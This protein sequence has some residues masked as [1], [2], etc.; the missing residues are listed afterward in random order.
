MIESNSAEIGSGALPDA[1]PFVRSAAA[2][3]DS[4]RAVALALTVAA[5]LLLRVVALGSAGFSEDEI[6]KLHAVNAYRHGDFSANGE[7]PMLMKVAMW[8]SLDGARWWNARVNSG[9]P[10]AISD[11]AAL[12]LPNA[13]AGAA[14]AAVLFL[15]TE[16]LFDTPTGA[17]AA[18]FW[19]CDVGA[20]GINRIG[21]EDTFLLF[22]L[23]LGAYL[24]ERGKQVRTDLAARERWYSRSA[25]AFGL[26]LAS[27][28]MPHYFGLHALFNVAGDQHPEDRTPDKRWPFFVVMAMAFVAGNAALLLPSTWRYVLGYVHGDTLRHSG[29]LFAQHLYVNNLDAS[30]WGLP[31]W[32]YAAFLA[33]KESLVTLGAAAVGA[34]WMWRHPGHRGGAFVRVFLV[35]TLLPY[36]FAASK[37]LRY[38]LPTLAAIDI[39]AAIGAARLVRRT[40]DA[41]PFATA[42]LVCA[43]AVPAIAAAPHY[44][45]A[46]N[47]V[48]ERLSPSLMFP[49]DELYDAGVR[50]AVGTVA[51]VASPGAVICSDAT[52]VVAEYLARDGRPDVTSRSIAH[53]GIPMRGGEVWVIAQDGHVY[54]ENAATLDAIQRRLA[55]WTEIRVG[56]V[57]AVRVYR[58]R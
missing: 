49:D 7:H 31:V 3:V 44:T 15:L 36:S 23:L 51:A 50:E 37:F 14:T 22:L 46:R 4:A 19:A 24:Y 21:K 8:A 58:F 45:L 41:A 53:D 20:A 16:A 25:V 43:L 2:T 47:L 39:A 57:S 1:F 28:Y 54:F 30:P 38:M 17:F 6:N 11:E 56:G 52:A 13:A 27:K 10:F 9:S 18:L 32:F 55:P 48:G 40:G 5:A 34:A 42:A 26:M 35:F 29:Y 12:R 33:T